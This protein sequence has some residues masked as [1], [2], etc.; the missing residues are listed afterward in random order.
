MRE[1][2]ASLRDGG[3][4]CGALLKRQ[5]L[6]MSWKVERKMQSS[7]RQTGNHHVTSEL[8]QTPS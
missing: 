2:V 4:R 6:L 7:R 5:L 3:M 1:K 8:F